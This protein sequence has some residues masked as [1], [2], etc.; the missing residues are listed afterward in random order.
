[1]SKKEPPKKLNIFLNGLP[2]GYLEYKARKDLIFSYLSDW[3]YGSR[4]AFPI[5]RSLPLREEPF[6]GEKVYAYFDNLL[7]TIKVIVFS[8]F[9]NSLLLT[10]TNISSF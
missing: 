7:S 5:S 3:L 6:E 1:M 4:H 9:S 10:R 2:V 8:L